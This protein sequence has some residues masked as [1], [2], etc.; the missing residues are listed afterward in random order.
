M[1]KLIAL[2]CFFSLHFISSPWDIFLEMKIYKHFKTLDMI[3]NYF[4]M[5]SLLKDLLLVSDATLGSHSNPAV[6][7]WTQINKS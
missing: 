4:R 1:G 3:N 7:S 2:L 5:K 6:R